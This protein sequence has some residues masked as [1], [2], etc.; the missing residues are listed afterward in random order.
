MN[1]KN[2]IGIASCKGGVGKSTV[3]INIAASLANHYNQKVGLLDADIYGPNHPSMLGIKNIQCNLNKNFFLPKKK[4]NLLSMSMGYFLKQNTSVL[5]RGPMVSNTIK[6]LLNNTAWGDLDFLIIDF[7][8]GTGDIYLSLLRDIKFSG[9]F[10]VTTPQITSI[11]DMQKSICMLTKFNIKIL[12]V[13]ENMKYYYCC[14]CKTN[15]YLSSNTN[16]LLNC[17]NKFNIKNVYT[18]PVNKFINDSANLGIPFVL[19]CS[20]NDLTVVFKNIS[21]QILNDV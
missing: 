10:L 2:I 21:K 12:G 4:F 14:T 8:P 7:P 17:I 19:N 20:N 18:L 5:L 16:D 9:F 1:I 3:S 15:N 13:L 11:D 6:Y